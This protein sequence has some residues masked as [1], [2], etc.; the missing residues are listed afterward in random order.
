MG[1][2]ND[3][4]LPEIPHYV[5]CDV[6]GETATV[7]RRRTGF[8]EQVVIVHLDGAFFIAINCPTCGKR[9]QMVAPKK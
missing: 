4:D 8:G 1:S 5:D 6:C 2:M 7:E 9:Q 3:Y